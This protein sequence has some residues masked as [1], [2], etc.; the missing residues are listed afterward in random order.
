MV[1]WGSGLSEEAQDADRDLLCNL[2]EKGQFTTY[3]MTP[4]IEIL[5]M[6]IVGAPRENFQAPGPFLW[7]SLRIIAS[8]Q[9][10][11]QMKLGNWKAVSSASSIGFDIVFNKGEGPIK[12]NLYLLVSW[13]VCLFCLRLMKHHD[14]SLFKSVGP[15]VRLPVVKLSS[16]ILGKVA[17]WLEFSCL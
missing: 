1:F 7:P 2:K 8:L 17:H 9:L 10:R 13:N 3:W 16:S 14:A 15:G 12:S 11:E 4:C 5:R 6:G